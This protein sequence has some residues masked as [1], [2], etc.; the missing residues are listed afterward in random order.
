M[1]RSIAANFVGLFIDLFINCLF[2][3]VTHLLLDR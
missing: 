3:F 1:G 2:Y